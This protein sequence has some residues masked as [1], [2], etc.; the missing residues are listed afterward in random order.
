MSKKQ[1]FTIYFSK[2]QTNNPQYMFVK[3]AITPCKSSSYDV[4]AIHA[5]LG[6]IIPANPP[7][8]RAR[9]TVS[10]V[11]SVE[12]GWERRPQ[13]IPTTLTLKTAKISA[14]EGACVVWC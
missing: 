10:F 8:P 14:F 4:S 5:N 11:A 1:L 12:G 9:K 3:N 2:S 7:K 13:I 6:C